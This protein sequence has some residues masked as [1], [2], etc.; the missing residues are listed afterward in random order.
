LVLPGLRVNYPTGLPGIDYPLTD[1]EVHRIIESTRA[2]L[3]TI[4]AVTLLRGLRR[5]IE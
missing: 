2:P 1:D 3:S 5:A 4:V